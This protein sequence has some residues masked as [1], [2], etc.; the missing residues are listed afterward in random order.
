MPTNSLK[1]IVIWFYWKGGHFHSHPGLSFIVL[2]SNRLVPALW[3]KPSCW[4]KLN[5]DR[6]PPASPRSLLARSLHDITRQREGGGPFSTAVHF[7]TLPCWK[8]IAIATWGGDSG[9]SSRKSISQPSVPLL[10]ICWPV[11]N[12]HTPGLKPFIVK[13]VLG[14]NF[15]EI[16]GLIPFFS[17]HIRGR[18]LCYCEKLLVNIKKCC[19][20]MITDDGR[21]EG[22]VLLKGRAFIKQSCLIFWLNVFEAIP[23]ALY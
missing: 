8:L 22:P 2:S 14:Y 9:V 13:D 18:D 21:L 16:I 3:T 10:P 23:F 6:A 19:N 5:W 12:C 7:K 11:L 4:P 1:R 17:I 15:L 20:E